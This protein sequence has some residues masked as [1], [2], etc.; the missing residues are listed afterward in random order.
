MSLGRHE[1]HLCARDQTAGSPRQASG[2]TRTHVS[3]TM[4]VAL[5]ASST[6]LVAF[7]LGPMLMVIQIFDE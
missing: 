4:N 2:Q 3:G 5:N 6:V 1:D 7:A